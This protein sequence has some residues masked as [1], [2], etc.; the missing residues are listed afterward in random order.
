MFLYSLEME[1]FSSLSVLL[2]NDSWAGDFLHN[3]FY[4]QSERRSSHCKL[5]RKVLNI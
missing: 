3:V 2:C 5:Q 4:T 1:R